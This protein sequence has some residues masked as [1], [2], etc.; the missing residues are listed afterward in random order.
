MCRN[1]YNLHGRRRRDGESEVKESV[2]KFWTFWQQYGKNVVF[3]GTFGLSR[4]S[5][6]A[7]IY[8]KSWIL[9]FG[10]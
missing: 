10:L 4:I 6:N 1:N 8:Y 2:L 9:M 5:N 7:K 3:A